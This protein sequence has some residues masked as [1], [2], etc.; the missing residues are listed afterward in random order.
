MTHE[1]MRERLVAFLARQVGAEVAV[2]GLRRLPGGASRETWSLDAVYGPPGAP[3]RVPLVLRRDPGATALESDRHGEFRLLRVLRE[4]GVPV[5]RVDWLGD[6]SLGAPFFLM[7]RV[8]GETLP[9][10]LL[11]DAEYAPAR[12]AMTAQ[13]GEILA[14]IHAVDWARPE[15]GHLVQPG[16]N[17]APAVA[18]LDRFE[19]VYRAVAPEAHPA[20]ELALRWL[21]A[22]VPP[23]RR[24]TLVHGDYRIGNVIF[25]PEGVRSIL[26]W[27]LSHV[28][29]PMEDLGWLCVRAWRFG[30]D[31]K[32][33]GG[34]GEREELFAAYARG[35]GDPVDP[36]HVRFWEVFGNLKW[37]IICITQAKT[38]LD[39]IVHSIELASLGRRTAETEL[40]LLNLIE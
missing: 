17:T 31:H 21:R 20:F 29:D 12:T 2:E 14:R 16:E 35:G 9:R 18:E 26:D 34:I 3:A 27:E 40:E 19:Q 28:G 15:L 22:R 33:V 32:P 8:E 38:H 7:E 4:A 13:L 25:G 11:R 24:L 6:D 30:R 39:G 1:E 23:A 5:P 36:A 10:R 37:A